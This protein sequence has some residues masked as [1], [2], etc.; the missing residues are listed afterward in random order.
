VH[1]TCRNYKERQAHKQKHKPDSDAVAKH[2]ISVDF[3]LCDPKFTTPE[4]G[5][6]PE[7]NSSGQTEN[8]SKRGMNRPGEGR[9]A[10]ECSKW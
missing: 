7:T 3:N 2:L 1:A 6:F 5:F 9:K 10:A 4:Y 8:T